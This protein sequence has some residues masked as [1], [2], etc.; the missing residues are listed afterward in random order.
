MPCSFLEKETRLARVPSG[1]SFDRDWRLE[2]RG[3]LGPIR[4]GT[5]D[6]EGTQALGEVELLLVGECPEFG[7]ELKD[8]LA[9]Q[10]SEVVLHGLDEPDVRHDPFLQKG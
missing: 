1:L 9:G 3:G 7:A 2:L 6:A 5:V 4:L 8:R 10:K